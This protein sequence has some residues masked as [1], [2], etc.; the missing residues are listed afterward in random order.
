MVFVKWI[1]MRQNYGTGQSAPNCSPLAVEAK[2]LIYSLFWILL[3]EIFL[4]EDSI[5]S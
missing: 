4:G 3:P 1:E 5:N 2:W